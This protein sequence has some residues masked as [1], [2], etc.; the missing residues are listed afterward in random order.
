MLINCLSDLIYV[1]K[2]HN[3]SQRKSKNYQFI[4]YFRS[5]RPTF[6]NELG[7]DSSR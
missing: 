5:N 6:N 2:L 7:F 1:S 3:Q 4:Q